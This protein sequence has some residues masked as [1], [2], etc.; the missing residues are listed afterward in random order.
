MP[1]GETLNS[2]F[3]HRALFVLTDSE[4][5]RLNTAYWMSPTNSD[6]I[7]IE[8]DLVRLNLQELVAKYCPEFNLEEEL[9][10]ATDTT[11]YEGPPKPKRDRLVDWHDFFFLGFYFLQI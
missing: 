10:K 8:L 11:P 5:E 2:L 6:D 1:E 4:D 3:N 9:K 7:D